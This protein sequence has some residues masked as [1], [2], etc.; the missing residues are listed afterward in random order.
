LDARYKT[1]TLDGEAGSPSWDPADVSMTPIFTALFNS[2][3][4]NDLKYHPTVPYRIV[5]YG[6][7]LRKWD[8][9]HHGVEPT[10]VAPDL[11]Q[12][13]TQDP[14]LHVFS[15]NG[16]FD[17][18]TP[19]FATVY[20]LNHLDLSPSLQKN[21]SFGFYQSGHMIYMNTPALAAYKRDLDAWYDRVL[22]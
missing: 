5:N 18:A 1:Y 13:M 6:Q 15:A 7:E 20:T 9:K 16:Y 21:I 3:V 14:H 12:A 8:F 4:R 2:Y 17:L 11:A 22:R 19:Y 10:N